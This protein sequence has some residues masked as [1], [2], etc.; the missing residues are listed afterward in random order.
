MKQN[1]FRV[2]LLFTAAFV[3]IF[4]TAC[5]TA[6]K[7]S[8][9]SADDQ[10]AAGPPPDGT[11]PGP[12]PNGMPPGPPPGGKKPNG[13][14]PGGG[15]GQ[16]FDVSTILATLSVKEG[17]QSKSNETITAANTNQ[18]A[19]VTFGNAV[20]M[21]DRNTISTTGRSSSSDNSSFQGLNAIVLSRDQ[22][23]INMSGNKLTSSGAGAN[24][25]FAYGKSVI[26]SERDVINCTGP[27]A[28]GLMAS[29][30]GTIV[31]SD[32]NVHTEGANSGAVATDRG[33]GI[34]TVNRGKISTTG[35]DSPALYSTGKIT[36]SDAE[37]SATG[38]EMAVIEGSNSIALKRSNMSSTKPDK[39]G[40]MIYQSFSGD[41][42]GVDGNF[43][44]EDG[45]L[46]YTDAKGPLFFVTNSVANIH[47][48]NVEITAPSG[49]LLKA[50]TGRWGHK[51]SN[52]GRANLTV[53]SQ[54]LNG[55]LVA[56]SLSTVSLS[57]LGNSVFTGSI[58]ADGQAHKASLN[59]DGTSSWTLAADSYVNVLNA[60]IS[61]DA[62]M[63]IIGNGHTV[64]Y[65]QA[66]NKRL[67]G[68]TY[69]LKQGGTLK[70]E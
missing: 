44:M 22:S 21:L 8:K 58:N 43:S 30:G 52:G 50:T 64:Y 7:M 51:G 54:T 63:N 32:V 24:A 37:L 68:K 16:K 14:P 13:M 47:L 42:E 34:I 4:A 11:P 57:L 33:S 49:I 27:Y 15:M 3:L 39:W 46:S 53:E 35:M 31:A 62:V 28:H 55:S 56:D 65:K 17:T 59:L 67:D 10:F 25:V 41:A 2:P 40:V 12:P 45:S 61:G 66:E 48:K 20:L 38:A 18:S 26:S 23:K 70:P 29:G 1:K 9:P 5:H 69:T 60:D 6:Q 19:V 36:V